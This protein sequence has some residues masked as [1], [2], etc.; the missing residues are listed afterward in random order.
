MLPSSNNNNGVADFGGLDNSFNAI[1][2]ALKRL[3]MS[4]GDITSGTTQK[5]KHNPI[6]LNLFGISLSKDKSDVFDLNKSTVKVFQKLNKVLKSRSADMEE[7]EVEEGI[8]SDDFK[9]MFASFPILAILGAAAMVSSMFFKIVAP[10][11]V[12]AKGGASGGDIVSNINVG[13]FSGL[14]KKYESQEKGYNAS[15]NDWAGDVDLTKKTV[16]EVMQM[17]KEAKNKNPKTVITSGRNKGKRSSAIGLYQI[18]GETLEEL[19]NKKHVVKP[20]DKFDPETQDKLGSYILN[21]YAKFDEYKKGSIT[22]E[23]FLKNIR[24]QWEGL[25]KAP[26]KEITDIT[27]KPAV[28][29]PVNMK[30]FTEAN[31]S[32][33]ESKKYINFVGTEKGT[34]EWDNFVRLQPEF[35]NKIK[36]LAKYYYETHKRK[37]NFQSGYRTASETRSVG[38][39][40]NSLHQVGL[41]SDIDSIQV[42]QLKKELKYFGLESLG[43]EADWKK[44]IHHLQNLGELEKR[45][46]RQPRKPNVRKRQVSSNLNTENTFDDK[47]QMVTYNSTNITPKQDTY[48]YYDGTVINRD[49]T[50]YLSKNNNYYKNLIRAG[51]LG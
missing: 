24:V 35:R 46:K 2:N 13:N 15:Y 33:E 29:A 8:E 39:S 23:Q 48:V 51:F 7:T 32:D 18:T 34:G 42:L 25:E 21:K 19:V 45:R 31:I 28:N 10:K 4:N 38:G 26:D 44:E 9:T 22:K 36:K 50:R 37:L 20:D 49:T 47:S 5:P 40:P 11:I 3:T 12:S 17:Q 27:P 16:R 6:N 41:A 43:I 30:K 1:K 14:I